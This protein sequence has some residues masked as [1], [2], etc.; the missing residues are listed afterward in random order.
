[1]LQCGISHCL[2]IQS[3]DMMFPSSDKQGRSLGIM[4]L[5]C[6]RK[7]GSRQGNSQEFL[8]DSDRSQLPACFMQQCGTVGL[9]ADF[10]FGGKDM[11]SN[12]SSS[13]PDP[14]PHKNTT[15]MICGYTIS[16]GWGSFRYYVISF[17]HKLIII[18]NDIIP[19]S[20]I[21]H[22]NLSRVI[23]PVSRFALIR[24]IVYA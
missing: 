1:M 22:S 8:Q 20:G 10:A 4:H 2:E 21:C 13:Q 14:L 6:I 3:T 5:Y 7:H 16:Y 15:R 17:V 9:L 18:K 23:S 19:L 11:E 24:L 12:A